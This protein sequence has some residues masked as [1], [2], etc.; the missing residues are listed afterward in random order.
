MTNILI[1][2]VTGNIGYQLYKLLKD[3]DELNLFAGVRNIKKAR[4]ELNDNEIKYRELD[5]MK[6]TTFDS[7]LKDINTLFLMRPPAIS[8]VKKYI[9]PFIDAAIESGVEHIVFLSLQGVENNKITPHYK[10]EQYIINRD[11]KYTFLRPSFFMENLTTTHK[12]EIKNLRKIIIPAGH[13]RTNFIAAYDI[14]CAAMDVITNPKE[15]S[16]AYELTG[17]HSYTYY[18]IAKIISEVIN[19]KVEYTNPSILKFLKYRK[20]KKE[21]LAY[22]L[23][24]IALYSVAKA[25]KADGYS[26]ELEILIN[27]KPITFEEFAEQNKERWI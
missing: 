10:I 21:K 4:N 15:S 6:N 7:S 22:I 16:T 23:V 12:D 26:D 17:N 5:F 13:G 2:G 3:A 8:K 9:F 20:R 11:I 14:A 18:E 19:D 27:R 25:G 1:T 24:M